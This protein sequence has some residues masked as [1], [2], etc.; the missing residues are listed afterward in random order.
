[1][2]QVIAK[3][4]KIRYLSATN[5]QSGIDLA[6]MHSPDLIILDM[7]LPDI[8]GIEGFEILKNIE[9]TKEIPVIA[10]S[11]NALPHQIE[12]AMAV[13]FMKYFVKPFEI[14]QFLEVMDE[15]SG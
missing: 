8:N 10:L 1:M 5:M 7:D 3:R 14:R 6:Q 12:E 9:E 4:P 13:G 2:E 15:M 11:A